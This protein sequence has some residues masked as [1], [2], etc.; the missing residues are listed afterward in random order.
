[1]FFPSAKRAYV[2]L[3]RGGHHRLPVSR[4]KEKVALAQEA[5][6]KIATT[7]SSSSSSSVPQTW[8]PPLAPRISSIQTSVQPKQAASQPKIITLAQLQ[9]NRAMR[10]ETDHF[11][12][13]VESR[14]YSL[15]WSEYTAQAEESEYLRR[16]E[17][18]TI[19][20]R[21]LC[22][23]DSLVL[24]SRNRKEPMDRD[25]NIMNLAHVQYKVDHINVTKVRVQYIIVLHDDTANSNIHEPIPAKMTITVDDQ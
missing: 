8:H 3:V 23:G 17:F 5:I 9:A 1:M 20:I 11:S 4:R 21:K 13:Y 14:N 18:H 16:M 19:Y 12:E 6:R 25:D 2:R 7:G 22:V 15:R 10:M 24:L